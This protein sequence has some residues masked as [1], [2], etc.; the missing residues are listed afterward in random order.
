MKFALDDIDMDAQLQRTII[1][2]YSGSA[3]LG[4]V[5]ATAHRVIPGDYDSWHAEW[6]TLAERTGRL[7]DDCARDG[8]VVSAAKAY[9]RATEYWRQAIFFIRHDLNDPRLLRGWRAARRRRGN[10]GLRRD[11]RQMP[12]K[13]GPQQRPGGA[14]GFS[15]E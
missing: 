2:A 3:D 12:A 1:A 6:A 5:L 7:A 8:P 9:L 15:R 11:R 4:E 14:H 10:P 13:L